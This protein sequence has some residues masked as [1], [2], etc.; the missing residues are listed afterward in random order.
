[1]NQEE[2]AKKVNATYKNEI[3][4]KASEVKVKVLPRASAGVV[5]LDMKLGGGVPRGRAIIFRGD[6]SSGKTTTALLA[7]ADNQKRCKHCLEYRELC[8][9]GNFENCI[10]AFIDA[11]GELDLEWAAKLG[12]NLDE[13]YIADSEYG[14]QTADIVTQSIKDKIYDMIVLDSI[15]CLIPTKEIEKSVED[16]IVG[17]QAKLVTRAVRAWMHEL[18]V[19]EDPLQKPAI[20]LI[21]QRRAKIGGMGDETMPGGYMLGHFASQIAKFWPGNYAYDKNDEATHVKINYQIVKNKVGL[22]RGSGSFDLWV[23]KTDAHDVGDVENVDSILLHG[24]RWGLVTLDLEK[25]EEIS[26][27][28]AIA[29]EKRSGDWFVCGTKVGGNKDLIAW[30]G[31]KSNFEK[32]RKEIFKRAFKYG[33]SFE[34]KGLD[35]ATTNGSIQSSAKETNTEI[36]QIPE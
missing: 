6:A 30:A 32:L 21:N 19:I 34:N 25:G 22:N 1:M 7:I 29:M 4:V 31:V 24:R 23:K 35:E 18:A 27:D 11:E 16:D 5:G 14:E 33:E 36:A 20:F 12:V 2:F 13:L 8:F 28:K 10:A 9:C 3:I 17:L 15:A 26:L